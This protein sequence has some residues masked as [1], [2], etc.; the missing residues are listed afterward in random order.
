MSDG[1]RFQTTFTNKAGGA[2]AYPNRNLTYRYINPHFTLDSKGAC[3]V[4]T[5]SGARLPPGSYFVALL[6]IHEDN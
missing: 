2:S 1:A 6:G 4:L 5:P 3:V